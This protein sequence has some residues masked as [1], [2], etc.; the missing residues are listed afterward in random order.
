MS[1]A[2]PSRLGYVEVDW[3]DV[4]RSGKG[5]WLVEGNC[6]GVDRED[7]G[8]SFSSFCAGLYGIN[9][10]WKLNMGK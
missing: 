2:D 4:Y 5:G 6:L 9:G 8:L 3:L 1:G 10:A 7:F